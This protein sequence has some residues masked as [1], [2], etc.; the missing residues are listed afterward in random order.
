MKSFLLLF[1]VYDSVMSADRMGVDFGGIELCQS[2][3]RVERSANVIHEHEILA[4]VFSLALRAFVSR[5]RSFIAFRALPRSPMCSAGYGSAEV[6]AHPTGAQ[7]RKSTYSVYRL[8][9][10]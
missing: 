10:P 1:R 5:F 4:D 8:A 3:G 9:E 7:P 6:N 2:R